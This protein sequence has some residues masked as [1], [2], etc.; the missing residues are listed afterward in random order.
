MYANP[1]LP[2]GAVVGLN[3][4]APGQA[5]RIAAQG[6]RE[7]GSHPSGAAALTVAVNARVLGAVG[8]ITGARRAVDDVRTLAE[9]LDGPEAADTW[10]GYPA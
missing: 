9:Q 10:F 8:D 1:G 3:H 5:A 6:R 4:G 7:A 2:Q